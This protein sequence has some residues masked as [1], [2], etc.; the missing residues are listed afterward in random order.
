MNPKD[1]HFVPHTHNDLGWQKTIDEYQ[2]EVID[3]ILNSSIDTM[4]E[5]PD[6]KFT[7]CNV[8][9][10][11][12]YLREHPDRLTNLQ[13]LVQKESMYIVNGGIAVHDNAC[14]HYEDIITNYEHGRHLVKSWFGINTKIG[15][16]IDPFGHS[17]TTTR[18]FKELGYSYYVLNRISTIQKANLAKSSDFLYKWRNRGFK[19]R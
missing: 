17:Q 4:T 6:K 18:I 10:L 16:L 11:A 9:F 3:S 5:Q 2:S 19:Y 12:N 14:S 15:W 7:Y 1:Y 13:K 8:G